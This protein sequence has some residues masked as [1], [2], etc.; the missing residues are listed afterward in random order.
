MK[1]SDVYRQIQLLAK[2]EMSKVTK[3]KQSSAPI[4]VHKIS[5]IDFYDLLREGMRNQAWLLQEGMLY[6]IQLACESNSD[7]YIEFKAYKMYLGAPKLKE[8]MGTRIGSGKG[9]MFMQATGYRPLPW[10]TRVETTINTLDIQKISKCR[11]RDKI[12]K[13]G[14]EL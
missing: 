9:I 3:L 8:E 2:Q 13:L 5:R 10:S 7:N 6:K 1:E 11:M 4:E 14:V 12:L